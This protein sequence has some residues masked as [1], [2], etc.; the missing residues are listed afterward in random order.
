MLYS[1]YLL[2]SICLIELDP[3]SPLSGTEVAGQAGPRNSS[4]YWL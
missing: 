4:G 3:E 1:G 2:I